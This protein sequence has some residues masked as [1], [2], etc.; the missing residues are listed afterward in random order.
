M[1]Y[2]GL[3]QGGDAGRAPVN[4]LFPPVETAVAGESSQFG[5]GDPFVF[6]VHGQVR[7]IPLPQDSQ[8]LELSSLDGDEFGGVFPAE[9]AHLQLGDLMFL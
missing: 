9:P 3:R 4:R 1:L 2:L 8:P 7:F 6:V 5:G